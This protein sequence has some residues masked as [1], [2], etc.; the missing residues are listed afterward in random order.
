MAEEIIDI[1]IQK[2]FI[3]A[4]L[5]CLDFDEAAR[6]AGVSKRQAKFLLR[7]YSN[8]YKMLF[9]N[10]GMGEQELA[11]EII[12]MIKTA[13]VKKYNSLKKQYEYIPDNGTKLQAIKMLA[14][15]FG[16]NAAA[17][18]EGTMLPA[19]D[20]NEQARYEAIKNDPDMYKKM[21]AIFLTPHKN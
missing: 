5:T 15:I 9:A 2:K 1:L 14:E 7:K 11:Q 12:T 17:R 13:T 21:Q 18:G 6:T 3:N 20:P 8:E 4:Y 10:L 16:M 19:A